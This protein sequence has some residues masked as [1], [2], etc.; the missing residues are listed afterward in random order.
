MSLPAPLYCAHCGA[1]NPA[2][3]DTCFACQHALDLPE[4]PEQQQTMLLHERYR[5][6]AQVGTGGFGAVYRAEDLSQD[7]EVVAVKQI[8]L[9]GLSAQQ[10]IEAT[11]GF[12]REVRLLSGLKHQ[13]L[14]AIH[15]SFTDP[16]HWYIVMD[17]IEGETLETYLKRSFTTQSV[18]NVAGLPL[19][20]VLALGLQLCTVLD[21]LHTRQPPIIFRDLKPAN[22]MRTPTGQVYLID[23]GIARHFIP[24][25]PKD[26]I[27]FGSP[28]YAPPEQYG[29]AQT[30][31]QADLYSLGALLHYMLSSDD[32]AESPF[33]FSPLRLYGPPVMQE[34]DELIQ[35]MVKVDASERPAS[36]AEVKEVLQR[37]AD[38]QEQAEPRLWRPSEEP[39]PLPPHYTAYT[40]WVIENAGTGQLQQ[41]VAPPRRVFSRRSL[42]SM[43]LK[44]GGTAL[45]GF[46]VVEACRFSFLFLGPHYAGVYVNPNFTPPPTPIPNYVFTKHTGPVTTIAWSP[47]GQYIVSGS[48]DKTALVWRANDGALVYKF[49]GY[50]YPLTSV[51]WSR[52]SMCVASGGA[53]DG[54]VQVWDAT[55]NKDIR[56][57]TEH[58]GKVL[59]LSWADELSLIASGGEDTT[60]HV[61]DGNNG[62]SEK[63]LHGHTASVRAVAWSFPGEPNLASASSDKTVRTWAGTLEL[64]GIYSPKDIVYRGHSAGVNALAWSRDG[65]MIASASDDGT[66]QVWNAKDGS[67]VVTYRGHT[68]PVSA[69][70][71]LYGFNNTGEIS[72]LVSGGED[73]TVQVWELSGRRIATY[74]GHT[75]PIR[76]LATR[77]YASDLRVAS[78]SEDGTVQMWT[79]PS[80]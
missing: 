40:G 15:D 71:W 42:I 18:G 7:S 11:D 21:Y 73:T 1:A 30:T 33:R 26:T 60:V 72:W 10:K 48:A 27:P 23:F 35:R 17:F 28:G 58:S 29:R 31:P 43:G 80:Q 78:A 12:Y 32:P 36:A 44:V 4:N 52:D 75:R 38:L 9:Q 19:K 22:I 47:S 37:L 50:Q 65:K 25:K 39:L 16:E 6:L 41:Q 14:P 76:S 34:L 66:V 57:F 20:E 13:N 3:S 45:V 63:V 77:P 64:E 24:G 62:K 68:G 69:V 49:I 2:G 79:V 5:L 53:D 51:T 70:T 8:N 55:D 54:T 67:H 74:N 61:W 59:A 56:S 46:A